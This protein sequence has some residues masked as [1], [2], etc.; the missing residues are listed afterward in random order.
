MCTHF[1][2]RE[3]VSLELFGGERQSGNQ[4]HARLV[5]KP[6]PIYPAAELSTDAVFVNTG[7][8]RSFSTH[9]PELHGTY[10]KCRE[11]KASCMKVSPV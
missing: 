9:E 11:K 1:S 8:A 3:K 5:S 2:V 6:K 10:Y 7:V 4:F